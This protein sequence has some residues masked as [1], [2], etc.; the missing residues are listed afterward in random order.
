MLTNEELEILREQ[1]GKELAGI[2]IRAHATVDAEIIQ[3]C[4]H[5]D[6]NSIAEHAMNPP[7]DM[8]GWKKTVEVELDLRSAEV[9]FAL[10]RM[11]AKKYGTC[12]GCGAAVSFEELLLNPWERFCARCRANM[13]KAVSN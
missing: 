11:K 10:Q 8:T 3:L 7:A 9:L 12:G 6:R 5:L 1:L 2:I 4:V 13:A